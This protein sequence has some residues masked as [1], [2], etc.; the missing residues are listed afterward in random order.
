MTYYYTAQKGEELL[1][2]KPDR[3]FQ[4]WLCAC[5]GSGV[6][7]PLQSGPGGLQPCA[8]AASNGTVLVVWLPLECEVKEGEFSCAP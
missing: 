8:Q 5:T 4:D 6:Q 7:S 3:A 1:H 2:G